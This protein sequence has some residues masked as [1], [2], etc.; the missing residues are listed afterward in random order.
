MP[1]QK[2]HKIILTVSFPDSI[3]IP[4]KQKLLPLSGLI[5]Q[6]TN[7]W[8]FSLFPQKTGFGI[9]WDNLPNPVFWGKK[10][11][12]ILFCMLSVENCIRSAKRLANRVTIVVI[13]FC[14]WVTHSLAKFSRRQNGYFLLFQGPVVQ[15]IISLTRS[16]VAK[17]S[18]TPYF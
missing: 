18:K 12:I 7:W 13:T 8:Y 10:R 6:M 14:N 16:L 3:S 11:K 4:F 17:M 9:S 5:Q 15:S 1:F 2:G